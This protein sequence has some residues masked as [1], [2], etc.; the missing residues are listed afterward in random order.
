ME[1]SPTTHSPN[2]TLSRNACQR[3]RESYGRNNIAMT[4]GERIRQAREARGM[5]RKE[6]ATA[7]E[8]PY[9]TLAGIE[10]G[11]Q[12]ATGQLAVIADVLEVSGK[13]LTTGQGQMRRTSHYV[14]LDPEILTQAIMFVEYD[15]TLS[16]PY[17]PEAKAIRLIDLCDM[18]VKDGG[19]PSMA[20]VDAIMQSARARKGSGEQP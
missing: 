1:T 3:D 13:W 19:K 15:E 14:T 7:I 6:L 9:S 20:T 10:T 8:M 4:I 12:G 11:D 17:S 18:I 16:G 2:P 5:S